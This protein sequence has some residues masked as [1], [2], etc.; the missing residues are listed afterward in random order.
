MSNVCSWG[1]GENSSCCGEDGHTKMRGGG[2]GGMV[3]SG[4]SQTPG[5]RPSGYGRTGNPYLRGISCKSLMDLGPGNCPSL[6][7]LDWEGIRLPPF[8]RC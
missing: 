7:D 3:G 1:R 2:K 8:H 5:M 6:C 4:S